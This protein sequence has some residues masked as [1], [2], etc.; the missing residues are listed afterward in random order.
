MKKFNVKA[1]ISISLFFLLILLFITAIS[2]QIIDGMVDPE[3][4][5]ALLRE[6]EKQNTYFLAKLQHIITAIHVIA[7]FLFVGLAAIHLIKNRHILKSY[8]MK[9]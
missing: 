9:K 1:V 6:P 8:L 3:T 4:Y 7:G 2:I 5:I